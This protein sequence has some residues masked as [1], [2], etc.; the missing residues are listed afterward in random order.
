MKIHE[1]CTKR[2]KSVHSSYRGKVV[3]I[4]VV[5]RGCSEKSK[6]FIHISIIEGTNIE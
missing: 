2:V 4:Y 5:E 6:Q 1:K 3:H